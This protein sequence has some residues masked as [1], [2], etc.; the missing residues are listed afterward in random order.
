MAKRTRTSINPPSKTSSFKDDLPKRITPVFDP[1]EMQAL[2]DDLGA[3]HWGITY[4]SSRKRW[5]IFKTSSNVMC[6]A[7]F[8]K[9]GWVSG[10]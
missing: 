5:E 7:H 8:G 10:K 3:E 2:V 4:N 1:V 6:I 9:Q